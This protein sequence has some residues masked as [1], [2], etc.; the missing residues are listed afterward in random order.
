MKPVTV[1][2][3]SH[4]EFTFQVPILYYK[5][6]QEGD[7]AAGVVGTLL[8]EAN[9]NLDYR[10]ARADAR[11]LL[12]DI[13]Q[14]LTG[15]EPLT[16]DTGEKDAQGQPIF[17]V[18]EN[19][20]KYV[21]RALNTKPNVTDAKVQSELT[22]RANG[23]TAADGTV[24]PALAV[25]AKQ[26]ERKPTGPKKL[27]QKYISLAQTVLASKNA[28]G[29]AKFFADVKAA[30]NKEFKPTGDAVVDATSLGWIIREFDAWKITQDEQ[31]LL[32]GL[33]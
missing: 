16:V 22:R 4:G 26:R 23:Y 11:A 13:V 19:D 9:L 31:R 12:V 29:V 1:S 21:Q 33:K 6:V 14:E 3:L 18:T 24:V 32:A 28:K 5:S 27:T 2:T 15:V 10:G 25:D 7:T 8:K 17:E 30:I 20:G